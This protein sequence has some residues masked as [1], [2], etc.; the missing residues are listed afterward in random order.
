[1]RF[2]F[3]HI[4]TD[5]HSSIRL[6]ERAEELGFDAAWLPDQAFYPD[7]FVL[8]AS[9][10]GRT[11]RIGVGIGVTNPIARHPFLIGRSAATAAALGVDRFRLGLGTGNR[12][13]YLRPLGYEERVRPGD[14]RTALG[15]IR[16]TVT[17]RELNYDSDLFIA[18]G[19]R[20]SFESVNIPLY[21]AGISPRLLEIAGA[22]ADG[23]I[24]AHTE[25]GLPSVRSHIDKGIMDRS[26]TCQAKL[27]DL[28]SWNIVRVV[29]DGDP[30][31]AYEGVR[32]F[33]AHKIAPS[34]FKTIEPLGITNEQHSIIKDAYWNAGA[35]EA[36]THVQDW[37]I[38]LWAWIG[39]P[40]VIEERLINLLPL[41]VSEVCF[42]LLSQ[43]YPDL[44]NQLVQLS[45]IGASVA[46]TVASGK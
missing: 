36:A 31:S 34:S 11:E 25:H 15:A 46:S 28:V 45:E 37:M 43:D 12:K 35:Q 14:F 8:V 18:R 21:V 42:L 2:S 40:Q 3:A 17:N 24:V 41:G 13:E 27:P 26:P 6:I 5:P 4:P 7:P 10:L 22:D 1:M 23:I 16:D 44:S 9:A 39:S 19:P 33:V 29:T 20:L 32:A 38:D 30:S